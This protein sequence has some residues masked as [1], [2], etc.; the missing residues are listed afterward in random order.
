MHCPK[1]QHRTLWAF[2][3][4]FT[5]F[6]STAYGEKRLHESFP[7]SAFK[8]SHYSGVHV[9]SKG[10][11]TESITNPIPALNK[12]VQLDNRT[13]KE[14]ELNYFG[15][16]TPSIAPFKRVR[17]VK[18]SLALGHSQKATQYSP[19]RFTEQT[20][21]GDLMLHTGHIEIEL[22]PGVKT[23]LPS[24]APN[25]LVKSVTSVPSLPMQ[26]Y[27]DEE[28]NFYV[29]SKPLTKHVTARLSYKVLTP[30]TYAFGS[31]GNASA[32]GTL[33]L[34]SSLFKSWPKGLK[35]E[36]R[37]AAAHLGIGPLTSVN[38]ALNGLK[39]HHRSF[40]STPKDLEKPATFEKIFY[41]QLGV[42][43]HRSYSFWIVA[44][45]LGL[46]AQ[47]VSNEA[48][49]W[50]E[51][52]HG[53]NMWERI[54]LGGDADT[55][56]IHNVEANQSTNAYSSLHSDQGFSKVLVHSAS[57]I[58]SLPPTNSDF[59]NNE[60]HSK[61]QPSATNSA[62][63]IAAQNQSKEELSLIILPPKKNHYE[64]D[65]LIKI[66]GYVRTKS[67][68]K[69]SKI[70]IELYL[71]PSDKTMSDVHLG[72]AYTDKN[73]DF[74]KD[75]PLPVE[76]GVGTFQLVASTPGNSIYKKSQFR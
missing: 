54:D 57:G 15:V 17:A 51:V 39:R 50:V 52:K 29:E 36:A 41:N 61:A 47:Y 62:E 56:N 40:Q 53:A 60:V 66:R 55:L 8:A 7:A 32:L 59:N 12:T 10:A 71:V 5:F 4:C 13:S 27:K 35:E 23:L 19:I 9:L 16:F 68:L 76:I 44:R 63:D 6:F 26:F 31:Y 45:S 28:H 3:Y 14:G 72:T 70:P 69:L 43:R 30:N 49:A 20:E 22:I 24:T 73:G 64:K 42:C 1:R 11:S 2:I 58:T 67:M 48:H 34:D 74:L 18:N 46:E 33:P 25:M 38:D 37:K 65:S 75:V 21:G